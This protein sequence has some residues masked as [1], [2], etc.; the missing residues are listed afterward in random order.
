MEPWLWVLFGFGLAVIPPVA[1]CVWRDWRRDTSEA[2]FT[3]EVPP[4]EVAR[5][6]VN[7]AAPERRSRLRNADPAP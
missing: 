6:A 4:S 7:H 1:Y 2:I 3:V 5:G